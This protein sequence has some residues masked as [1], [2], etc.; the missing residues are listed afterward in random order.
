VPGI[1]TISWLLLCGGDCI[2]SISVTLFFLDLRRRKKNKKP[3]STDKTNN[4]AIT[5]PAMA[6]PDNEKLDVLLPPELLRTDP[7]DGVV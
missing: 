1:A 4:R 3:A 6:P 7:V 5:I 2:G